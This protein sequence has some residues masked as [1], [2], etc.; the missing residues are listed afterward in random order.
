MRVYIGELP[1]TETES[2]V[3]NL[4]AR[5]GSIEKVEVER[6]P[7]EEVWCNRGY[8]IVTFTNRDDAAAAI[9]AMNGTE[10]KGNSLVV[11]SRGRGRGR[12]RG[13]DVQYSGGTLAL[14]ST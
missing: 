14:I 11:E 9:R 7:Y 6:N 4:F 13:R 3:R 8:A 5:F 1:I 2:D 10:L 12:G